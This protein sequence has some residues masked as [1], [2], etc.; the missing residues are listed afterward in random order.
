MT[1]IL[2]CQ[3]LTVTTVIV[4]YQHVKVKVNSSVTG[5]EGQEGE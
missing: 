4:K 5:H 2:Y 3:F 1:K